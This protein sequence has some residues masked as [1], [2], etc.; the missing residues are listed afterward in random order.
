MFITTGWWDVYYNRLVVAF[1]ANR[2]DPE[3]LQSPADGGYFTY[4]LI[5]PARYGASIGAVLNKKV[6]VGLDYELVNYGGAK[7]SSE[8]VSDFID[9][10]NTIKKKYTVAHNI[11]VGGE[12]NINPFMLRAGYNMYGSPFGH[13]FSGPFVRHTISGGGGIRTAGGFYADAALSWNITDEDYYPFS[14]LPAKAGLTYRTTSII[15]TAGLR[16]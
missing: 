10:N 15:L 1:D 8:R 9:V 4:D 5:T 11:R 2:N 6:A 12:Y 3:D 13:L 16:F 14:V 7:F